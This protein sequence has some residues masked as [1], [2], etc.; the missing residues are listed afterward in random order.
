MKSLK[1]MLQSMSLFCCNKWPEQSFLGSTFLKRKWLTILDGDLKMTF[2]LQCGKVI[3]I[4]F[5]S[6]FLISNDFLPRN[7]KTQTNSFFG[8]IQI[9]GWLISTLSKYI[10]MQRSKFLG[11]P[12]LQKNCFENSTSRKMV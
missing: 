5:C 3:S 6:R 11:Y 2:N 10:F 9:F 7:E 4:A 1:F 12:L 8:T